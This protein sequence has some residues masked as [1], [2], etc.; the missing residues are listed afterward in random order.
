MEA[1]A[2]HG[3]R[4]IGPCEARRVEA[5]IVNY[6]ADMTIADNPYGITGLER[7]VEE[8][9]ADYVGKEALMQI[10]AEGVKRKLVGI[11]FEADGLPSRPPEPW[12]AY[13]DGAQVG[14]VTAAVWSPRLEKNIGYVWVPIELA[15][16]GNGLAVETPHGK[17][18][19]QTAALP[20]FDPRKAIPRA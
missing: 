8:Q 4:P 14:R 17:I 2:A 13:H 3:I 20:F 9:A 16:P 1:G 12:P 19:G 10:K 18:E 6:G 15:G 11:E 5:G 7:L